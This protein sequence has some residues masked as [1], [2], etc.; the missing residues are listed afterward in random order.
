MNFNP[1][2][3]VDDN[4]CQGCT[5]P[6]AC[7]YDP[8]ADLDD[9]SCSTAGFCIGCTDANACNFEP[10]ATVDNG[11]CDYLDECGVCGGGGIPA[12]QCD[13]LGN[14]T[15]ACGVCGGEGIPEGECDCFGNVSDQCGVCGGDG[16][17]CLGCT[18]ATNP[19]YNP[20]AT[21]DDGSCLVG[22]CVISTACN[23]NAGADY[24]IPGACEFSS[25]TGCMDAGACNFDA[26][27]SFDNGLCFY[28]PLHYDCAGACLNDSMVMES[29]ILWKQQVAPTPRTQATILSPQNRT[30]FVL[31]SRLHV[32]ICV[33]LQQ[34]S[35]LFG[36]Q[37]VRLHKLRR[38]H[39]CVG[40]HL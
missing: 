24:Q 36:C 19:G 39:R 4:S 7:N 35:R 38:V 40:L 1:N 2:A 12:G 8:E 29:V 33:Q 15:D 10:N 6:L 17:S 34:R 3:N 37:H 20:A 25:C 28:P 13:C 26:Q 30:R 11:T 22:G 9:G 14:V 16:T 5:N 18:D 31:D 32:V 23:Y 27:A 21:I